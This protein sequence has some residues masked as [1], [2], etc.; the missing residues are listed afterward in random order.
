MTTPW[1]MPKKDQ[2]A[3]FFDGRKQ[4]DADNIIRENDWTPYGDIQCQMIEMAYGNKQPEAKL[5]GYTIDFENMIQYNNSDHQKQRRVCCHEPTEVTSRIRSVSTNFSRF[6]APS[7]LVSLNEWRISQ[8]PLVEEWTK[9]NPHY[10]HKSHDTVEQIASGIVIEGSEMNPPKTLEAQYVADQLLKSKDKPLHEIMIYCVVLYT[11]QSFIYILV[12]NVLREG[13]MTKVDT[14]GPYCC[15]LRDFLHE[16]QEAVHETVYR[17]TTLTVEQLQEYI[18]S[19]G[20]IKTWPAFSSTSKSPAG[21]ENFG[22]TLFVIEFNNDVAPCYP[23]RA[24]ASYS[25]YKD[26]QEI[27]LYPG[28]DFRVDSVEESH[29]EQFKYII[30]LSLM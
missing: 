16:D 20:Q 12:N 15:M 2:P 10:R 25:M 3:W 28:V 14:L 23:G 19:K 5:D 13:G 24:I 9:R 7:K 8:F 30:H 11:Y 18:N 29:G 22:N 26:E 1:Y 6:T 21:L 4:P 17:A 27:L